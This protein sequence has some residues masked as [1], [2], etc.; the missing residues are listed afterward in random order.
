MFNRFRVAKNQ[1]VII[2]QQKLIVENQKHIVEEKQKEY[3][4]SPS[5]MPGVQTMV[6]LM[7]HHI[8]QGR[9]SL[10]RLVELVCENPRHIFGCKS[11]GRIEVGLDADLTLVD[12]KRTRSI[13]NKLMARKKEKR[14]ENFFIYLKFK[15]EW[16]S[17]MQERMAVSLLRQLSH[18]Y[19]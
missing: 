4:A 5:G 16:L 12:L 1:K 6:P 19:Q 18:S 15:R 11:K 2:E 9:L 14:T 8:S 3:P 10:A 17:L 7:L 13:E